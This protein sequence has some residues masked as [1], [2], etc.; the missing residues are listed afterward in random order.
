MLSLCIMYREVEFSSS[1]SSALQYIEASGHFQAWDVL[2]A[3]KGNILP[4]AYEAVLLP[5]QF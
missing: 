4:V 5:E 1:H 3:G 2:P